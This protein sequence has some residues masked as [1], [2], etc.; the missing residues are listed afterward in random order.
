MDREEHLA[1][2][3][4]NGHQ[5]SSGLGILKGVAQNSMNICLN[6]G[7]TVEMS[8]TM[9]G[10]GDRNR[11]AK[12]PAIENVTSDLSSLTVSRSRWHKPASVNGKRAMF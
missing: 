4:T 2:R 6:L 12:S 10:M 8:S 5:K 3:G 1:A 11:E 7:G 9:A